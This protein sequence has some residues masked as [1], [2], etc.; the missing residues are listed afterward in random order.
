MNVHFQAL[1]V[2]D[3]QPLLVEVGLFSS[4][5]KPDGILRLLS[6]ICRQILMGLLSMLHDHHFPGCQRDVTA[7]AVRCVPADCDVESRYLHLMVFLFHV[8]YLCRVGGTAARY[9]CLV[10]YRLIPVMFFHPD[11]TLVY[12]QYSLSP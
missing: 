11:L 3:V 2:S 4:R 7:A 9:V 8:Y 12:C 1:G 6:D 5:T 10:L